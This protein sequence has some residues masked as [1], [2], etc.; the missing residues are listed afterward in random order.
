MI[1]ESQ[2]REAGRVGIFLTLRLAFELVRQLG[3]GRDEAGIDDVG[4]RSRAAV[5]GIDQLQRAH[6]CCE[7]HGSEIEHAL[8]I[9]DL[10][11]LEMQAVALECPEHLLDAPAQLIERNDPT[12][13]FGG[14][15]RMGRVQGASR[16]PLWGREDRSR[17]PLPK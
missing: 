7:R 1:Q 3:E 5:A 16:S 10:T 6:R 15:Y 13:R 9:G 11:V 4:S 14:M 17:A 12:R 8:A 2:A